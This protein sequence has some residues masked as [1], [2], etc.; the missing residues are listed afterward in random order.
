[1]IYVSDKARNRIATLM[2]ESH[3]EGQPDFFLREAVQIHPMSRADFLKE[4][5]RWIGRCGLR[6]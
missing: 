1:M 6:R 2:K 3:I 5:V 4:E